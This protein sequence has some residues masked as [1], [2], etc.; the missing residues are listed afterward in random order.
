MPLAV[1]P[2]GTANDFARATGLPEDLDEA[3]EL[4]VARQRRCA[5]WTWAAWTA[6]RS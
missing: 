4:A 2:T 3:C 5:P 6:A 1:L